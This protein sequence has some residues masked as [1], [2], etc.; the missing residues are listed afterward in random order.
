[1]MVRSTRF[2]PGGWLTRLHAPRCLA[3]LLALSLAGG[4]AD[5][6]PGDTEIVTGELTAELSSLSAPWSDGD[7]GAVGVA[8]SA[9]LS[10]GT[11]SVQGS[12]ADIWGNADAFH[13]VYQRLNGNTQVIARVASVSNTDAW[14]KAGVMIRENLTPGSRHA[15]VAVTPGNGVSFQSRASTGGTSTSASVSGIAAPTWVKLARSGSQLSAYRSS[16]G[17]TWTQ[18]GSTRTIDMAPVIYVGLAVTSHNNGVLNSASFSNV[19][20]QKPPVLFVTAS[21]TLGSADARV[22]R[23]LETLGYAVTVKDAASATST[24]ANGKDLVVVSST[25]N[26][27]SV[28]TKFTN[29]AVPLITWENAIF[30]DLGMT[31]S[32]ANVDYGT[33]TNQ[34][35]LTV[36]AATCDRSRMYTA[37]VNYGDGCHDLAAGLSGT[38]RAIRRPDAVTWG[39]PGPSAVKIASLAGDASKAVVFGY[40][41]GAAMPGL[42][43][44]P[45]RRVGLFMTDA[46][47]SAWTGRGQSLFDQAVYWATS[48]RYALTKKA[49]LLNFDPVLASQ[50]N[51]RMHVWG[52]QRYPWL[53][54]TDPLVLTREYLADITEASGG[55]VR[56]QL[57]RDPNIPDY[58]DRWLPITCSTQFNSAGFSE[59]QYIDA[60]DLGPSQGKWAEAGQAMPCSGA[61]EGDYD[62]VLTDYGVDAKVRSGAVDEVII[63][64]HPYSGLSESRMA[65]SSAYWVNG[66]AVFRDAPNYMVMGL[67]YERG[68]GEALESFGHRAE[69]LLAN[70]VYRPTSNETLPYNGCYWPDFASF[71]GSRAPTPQRDIWDRFTVVDGNTPDGAGVGAVHWAPNVQLRSQEYV[72]SLSNSVSSMADDW[73]FNYPKLVGASTKRLVN[74]D[75]WTPMASDGDAGRGFKKW[76]YHHMPRVPG[77]YA[78]SAN[79][80]ND[81]KLNNWWEYIVNFRRHPEMQD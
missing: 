81:G 21:T 18:V 40:D 78:D 37:A 17:V 46:T 22:K 1:M 27:A 68:I 76:W 44:A 57:V 61:Y 69:Q 32:A 30:D 28:N 16:D 53:W 5:V 31:G 74:V 71:C 8:G 75:E 47:A 10:S 70:H 43:A 51:V 41:R 49:L 3:S 7:I 25:V 45:A 42:A 29:V 64:G 38:F 58:L 60:Y 24:D 4:C 67:S 23:R 20:L 15:F 80:G 54:T 33:T 26:S 6:G 62:R 12:G 48:T 56:W 77:H 63:Y 14:A 59:Q 36:Y 11:F 65:G 66:P 50:G 9:T 72:W 73:Q 55:Y 52:N 2:L 35:D 19:S 34:Q 79:V 39:K 13:Y